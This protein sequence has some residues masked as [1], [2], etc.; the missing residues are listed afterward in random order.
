VDSLPDP[1]ASGIEHRTSGSVVRNSDHKTT[2]AVKTETVGILYNLLK[3]VLPVFMDPKTPRNFFKS[4]AT[5]H[6]AAT[7]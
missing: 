1:I 2:E 5:L 3:N 6:R 7:Q 4:K